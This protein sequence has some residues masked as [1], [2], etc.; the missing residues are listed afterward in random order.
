MFD[1]I[2]TLDNFAVVNSVVLDESQPKGYRLEERLQATVKSASNEKGYT[3]EYRL[4]D[5]GN[6]FR[7]ALI[8]ASQMGPQEPEVE[9]T[10]AAMSRLK[11]ADLLGRLGTVAGFH[12]ETLRGLDLRMSR[13]G[14]SA[15]SVF[16]AGETICRIG[17]RRI[18]VLAARNE[19]LARRTTLLRNLLE[20]GERAFGGVRIWNESLPLVPEQASSL[21]DELSV[22]LVLPVGS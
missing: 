2:G 4:G 19:G 15:R 11:Y 6:N 9:A 5:T 13:V 10:V 7:T 14:E 20:V 16:S 22:L 17:P 18:V 8:R 12:G 1:F 3:V 21:L